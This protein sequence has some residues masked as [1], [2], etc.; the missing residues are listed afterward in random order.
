MQADCVDDSGIGSPFLD[1]PSGEA[2]VAILL[3]KL[4]CGDHGPGND[5]GHPRPFSKHPKS[6]SRWDSTVLT[7]L[8][9][10]DPSS[11]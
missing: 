9:L 4:W 3:D 1:I 10:N 7:L 6:P 11:V 8:P 5:P 2:I